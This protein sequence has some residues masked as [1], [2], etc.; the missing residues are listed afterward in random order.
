MFRSVAAALALLLV[1]LTVQAQAGVHRVAPGETLW[2]IA[3]QHYGAPWRWQ[4]IHEANRDVVEDPHRIYPG[5][6]LV[7]P[8]LTS[9]LATPPAPT[10]AHR[11]VQG[12]TLWA[13]AGQHYG[14][15]W[16]WQEIHEA[17]L[18]V[19]EDPHWIYPGEELIIPGAGPRV[20]VAPGPRVDPIRGPAVAQREAPAPSDSLPTP[21]PEPVAGIG[22]DLVPDS[23]LDTI[24]TR[25]SI[26]DPAPNV[27]LDVP[28]TVAEPGPIPPDPE[29]TP[30]S[31]APEATPHPEETPTAVVAAQPGD[32][33]VQDPV[34]ST[35][36][37]P[38]SEAEVAREPAYGVRPGDQIET[39]FHTAAAEPVPSIQGARVVDRMGNVSF[40]FIG[41]VQVAGLDAPA[42]RS[43]LVEKFGAFYRDPVITLEVKLR[44]NVT[45]LVGRAG[46]YLLEPSATVLDAVSTAGGMGTDVSVGDN[47][48]SNTAAVQL[49]RDGETF[50]LDLRPTSADPAAL[51][52]AVR[53]GD[54]I[55]VPPALRSRFRDGIQFWGSLASLFTSVVAAIVII[56]GG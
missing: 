37:R 16:R 23:A 53:S 1:P 47:P 33:L 21:G 20:A 11:V 2:A 17:N 54:W 29:P 30:P 49:I 38:V 12:E 51:E 14:A 25:V 8:T 13:I 9:D 41:S 42:L 4:E 45:G 7:I 56:S 48:A 39:V 44:V 22:R 6:E 46:H 32:S 27:P 40:P 18:E 19:V 52:M 5:E 15:P 35:S 55:H 10:D 3:G 36:E 26:R 31:L 43:L 50:L 34:P 28:D 24:R